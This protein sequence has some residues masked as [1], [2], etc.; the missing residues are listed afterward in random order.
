TKLDMPAVGSNFQDHPAVYT[1]WNVTSAFPNPTTLTT[2]ETFWAESLRLYHE[3]GT[4]PLTKSQASYVGF[5]DLST[6][7]GADKANAILDNLEAQS[8]SEYL[9]EIYA[10]DD[11]LVA[12]YEAQRQ[13]L[14]SNLRNNEVAVLELP[15]A[16]AGRLAN[17][18]QKP[19]SRG[20]VHLNPSDPQ[21]VPQVFHATLMNP[22]DAEQVYANLQFTRKVMA[23]DAMKGMAPV[24]VTPGA[25]YAE[26]DE[27]IEGLISTGAL[28]P[29]F[30]HPSCSCPMMP[31]EMGGCVDTELKV[32]GIK[33][34]SIID[35]S[36]L[37]IIPAAH[38]QATMYAVA[39]KASD[40]I[41]KRNK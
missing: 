1:N 2:N 10:T 27:A 37:P 12:G 34:L 20:T 5:L 22:F 11:R 39:E 23:A 13:A 35:A 28:T 16:G 7:A 40:I 9:P 30:S 18:V 32:Y 15:F 8:P 14:I 19:L 17:A 26:F 31:E 33:G 24:E 3:E 29:T 25:Q 36:I 21:G 4:G 38:L 41:K 6:V